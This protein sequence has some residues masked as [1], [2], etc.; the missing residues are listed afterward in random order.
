MF[1]S[2]VLIFQRVF[3]QKTSIVKATW[4]SVGTINEVDIKASEYLMETAHSFRVHLKT[5]LQG[6][7]SKQNPNPPPVEKPNVCTVWV[8]KSFP[9]WQSC[10]LTVLKDHFM[11]L[12]PI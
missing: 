6:I 5:Y 9:S 7:K 3:L 4:P 10:I 11:V 1:T 12:F 2:V 8:A